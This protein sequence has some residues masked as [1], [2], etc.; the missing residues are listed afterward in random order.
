MSTTVDT[1]ELIFPELSRGFEWWSGERGTN[2][3]TRWFGT[4]FRKGGAL[5]GKHGLG[6]Y[7]GEMYWDK[8]GRH[9]VAIYPITGTRPDGDPEVSEYAEARGSYA[10][11][12]AALDAVPGLILGL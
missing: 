10:T 6:G 7:E 9:H 3:Y 12:Q 2:Y 8:G 4:A 1:E 5:A 11:E